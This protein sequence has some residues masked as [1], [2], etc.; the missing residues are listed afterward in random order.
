MGTKTHT[1][2]QKK[3]KEIEKRKKQTRNVTAERTSRAT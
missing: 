3:K 2:A 1:E